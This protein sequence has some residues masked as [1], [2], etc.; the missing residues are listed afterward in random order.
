MRRTPKS[1][2]RRTKIHR[3]TAKRGAKEC[4]TCIQFRKIKVVYVARK[5]VE[6]N[7]NL[8]RYEP[9]QSHRTDRPFCIKHD[10]TVTVFPD[11]NIPILFACSLLSPS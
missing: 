2:A 1:L 7:L 4:T 5:P 9:S 8:D 10:A 11:L 6:Y 3:Y